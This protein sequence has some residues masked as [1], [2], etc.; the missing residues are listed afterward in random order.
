MSC[1]GILLLL[2]QMVATA[3]ILGKHWNTPCDRML[4]VFIV[5]FTGRLALA[6]PLTVYRFAN[7]DDQRNT[8]TMQF[9]QSAFLVDSEAGF[10]CVDS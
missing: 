1:I 7:R 3:V 8:L 10:V 5:V 9:A 6:V 2:F 4:N